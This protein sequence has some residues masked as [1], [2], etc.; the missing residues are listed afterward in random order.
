MQSH[1]KPQALVSLVK[2]PLGISETG[3]ALQSRPGMGQ[4]SGPLYPCSEQSWDVGGPVTL[5]EVG[6]Q[7]SP[8]EGLR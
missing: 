2:G 5:G 3:L 8:R 1:Q 6:L 7:G 4:T